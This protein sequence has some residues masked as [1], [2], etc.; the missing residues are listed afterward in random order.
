METPDQDARALLAACLTRRRVEL[1]LSRPELARRVGLSHQHLWRI[2]R[3]LSRPSAALAVT[4]AEALDLPVAD[5]LGN[6]AAT[7]GA[8]LWEPPTPRTDLAHGLRHSREA[9]ALTQAELAVR[10]GLRPRLITSIEQGLS[11][12][13]RGR[14]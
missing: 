8:L 7:G 13:F 10:A 9:R 11:P 6:D 2:E 12:P 4:L 5:L 14:Y 3:G 1:G